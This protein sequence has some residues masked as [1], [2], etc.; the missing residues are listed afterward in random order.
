MHTN[1]AIPAIDSTWTLLLDRDG[2]INRQKEGSYIFH[3]G[4]F[5]F[6]PGV[7]PAMAQLAGLFRT[8]L[9]ITNQRGVGKG[10]MTEAALHEVHA[11][12]RRETEAAGGRI[13]GI[14]Y[15][16]DTDLNSACRKPNTGM[17]RDAVRDF[18]EC[19]LT[20]SVMI[21]NSMSD[22]QF[23]RN[24]GAYTIFITST[25]PQVTRTDN[26]IDAVFDSLSAATAAMLAVTNLQKPAP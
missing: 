15:C 16:T 9:V 18:P 19:E 1:R 17:A 13:D 10:L 7:L 11:H 6:L 22:M 21:G 14:Y 20:R 25:H 23:G 3:P 5:V 8:I 4:E 24:V 12:M 26:T 2:V